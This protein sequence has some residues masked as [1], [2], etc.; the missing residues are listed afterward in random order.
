MIVNVQSTS[1]LLAAL[2]T[3]QAGDT[4][5]VAPGTYSS[6][7]L[8][9]FKFNGAVKIQSADPANPAVFK[10]MIVANSSGL[11]FSQVGFTTDTKTAVSVWQGSN[12]ITFADTDFHGSGGG[13]A[14]MIRDA[15][16]ITVAN[17]DM[18]GF[19][20]GINEL[21][22]HYLT[23]SNNLFHDIS[24]SAIRGTGV[25]NQTISGNTF[26]DAK[27]SVANHSDVIHLW[28]GY[29]ESNVVV[30]SDNLF[31]P[32]P[33][34][35]DPAPSTPETPPATAPQP[36]ADATPTEPVVVAPPEP[37]VV[38]PDPVAPTP[39]PDAPPPVGATPEP[40]PAAPEGA[41][42]TVST[43][44][45]LLKALK[46]A[47][48]GDVIQLQAGTYDAVSITNLHFDGKVTVT[49]ASADAAVLKGLTVAGSSGLAFHGLEVQVN[50]N[51]NGVNVTNATNVSF[52]HMS[53]HGA[54]GALQ[55]VAFFVRGSNGV[56]ITDSEITQ[57]GS[58]IG[59][60]QSS[61]LNFSNNYIH[62]VATDGIYGAASAQVVV[63]G[64]TITDFHPAVG[65]HPDAI[66]FFGYNGVPSSDVV[67]SN[68][69]I[70]RGSGDPMQGIFIESTKNIQI[71][72]N[73]MAGT[74]YNGIGL[75]T[76]SD[77]LISNNF[78]VGFSDMGARIITRGASA[79][80]TVEGN[81]AQQIINYAANGEN[82]NYLEVG[83]TIVGGSAMGDLSA[84]NAWLDL[85]APLTTTLSG[86]LGD[87]LVVGALGAESMAKSMGDSMAGGAGNDT[88]LVDHLGDL[89]HEAA[90]AGLDTVQTT[91]S[92]Y[93]LGA[94]VERLVLTGDAA[95]SGVGNDLNNVLI[96][97]GVQSTL[98]G[99]AGADTLIATGGVSVLTGGEGADVFSFST[100][101]AT[102]AV[103][104]DFTVGEDRLDLHHLLANYHGT[105]PVAD[106]WLQVQSDGAGVTVLVDVDGAAGAAGFTA[107]AKLSGVTSLS[108]SDWIIQ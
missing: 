89:V 8:A 83:N 46:S 49:A 11:T 99:G 39:A 82:P 5:L 72:G 75:S 24:L 38:A 76:T 106:K 79:N 29:A 7:I 62:N 22:S 15:N 107:V 1:G 20:N 12:N 105:N 40:P 61:E 51:V 14:M 2:K 28:Q 55:G 94:N 30:T 3:A 16:N 95:Q 65:A 84:L 102:P 41:T 47:Q 6:V 91:L 36:P 63:S 92:S 86:G 45:E 100:L 108:A 44:A 59:H 60:L 90:H 67:I 48:A 17:S 27:A 10:D 34:T 74:M 53:V 33:T 54:E 50:G 25:T 93:T 23:I 4:I 103:I 43:T 64:N 35:A 19:V 32:A 77:A 57:V 81:T 71:T 73:A 13:S 18:G 104:T 58:G 101:P 69:I 78:V 97:N 56:A 68:N 85:R 52:A 98:H 96:G 87:D 31:G 42:V 26:A 9:N 80:V 88:Y 66:Q 37:V 21:N 70:T